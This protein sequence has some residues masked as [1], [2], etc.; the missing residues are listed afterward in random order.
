M[1]GKNQEKTW[2]ERERD[3]KH[4]FWLWRIRCKIG[5]GG[6]AILVE[7]EIERGKERGG[8]RVYSISE[9]KVRERDEWD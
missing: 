6:E 3:L 8:E 9:R 5:K 2:Q 1:N 7:K 4:C